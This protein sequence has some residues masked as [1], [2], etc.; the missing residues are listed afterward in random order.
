MLDI[1]LAAERSGSGPRSIR[2]VG[3]AGA[4]NNTIG[5]FEFE[6]YDKAG[7]NVC[8]TTG[9]VPAVSYSVNAN[10]FGANF[11]TFPAAYAI[12]GNSTSWQ[13]ATYMGCAA[14]YSAYLQFDFPA[15]FE[16]DYW[17]FK[18][19]GSW[20]PVGNGIALQILIDGVWTTVTGTRAP[21]NWA[22]NTWYSF[23]GLS[24]T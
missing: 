18:V 24:H 20:Y 7:R 10:K 11:T 4:S 2:L 1:M 17:R 3:L 13:N 12:D 21:A 22:D 19:E 16:M 23:T 15:G 9:Y 8:R 14:D 5:V 6:V